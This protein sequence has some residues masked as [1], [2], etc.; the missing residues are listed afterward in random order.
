MSGALV[1]QHISIYRRLLSR[2][3]YSGA[4]YRQLQSHTQRTDRARSL[5]ILT[6]LTLH[7]QGFVRRHAV[8]SFV[9]VAVHV[10]GFM[11]LI[12]ISVTQLHIKTHYSSHQLRQRAWCASAK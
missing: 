7:V 1:L 2:T 11:Q 12:S 3:S 9:V 8:A 4:L 10:G 6:I 5:C